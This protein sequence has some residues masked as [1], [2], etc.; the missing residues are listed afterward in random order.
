MLR[1]LVFQRLAL[2][3]E[4]Q[5]VLSPQV[6]LA[7]FG[8]FVGLICGRHQRIPSISMSI[9]EHLLGSVGPRV[10]ATLVS[11]SFGRGTRIATTFGLFESL[12][13]NSSLIDPEILWRVSIDSCAERTMRS[14]QKE[15]FDRKQQDPF[16]SYLLAR[17]GSHCCRSYRWYPSLG[18][19]CSRENVTGKSPRKKLKRHTSLARESY[20]W[21]WAVVSGCFEVLMWCF[22]HR[23][24]PSNA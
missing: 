1:L 7:S 10:C 6:P 23:L 11:F 15:H 8:P 3:I 21:S 2:P 13:G 19:L 12:P 17:K 16:G 20:L 5:R 24:C 4:R 18:P 22:G 14:E 9:V